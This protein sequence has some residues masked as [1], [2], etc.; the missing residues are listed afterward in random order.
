MSVF[1]SPRCQIRWTQVMQGS[2]ANVAVWNLSF[3]LS[4]G[5]SLDPQIWLSPGF[6]TIRHTLLQEGGDVIA[7]WPTQG[8]T[9]TDLAGRGSANIWVSQF[10]WT[11]GFATGN[12]LGTFLYRPSIQFGIWG[13]GTTPTSN[14]FAVAEEEHNFLL[15]RI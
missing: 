11:A 6:F 4:F 12:R 14:E 9:Q 1:H 13:A 15:T 7:I 2:R 8:S 3:A 5:L 10:F